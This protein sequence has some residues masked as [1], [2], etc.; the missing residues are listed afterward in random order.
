MDGATPSS[1]AASLSRNVPPSRS[2]CRSCNA[3]ST[4]SME[5]VGRFWTGFRAEEDAG[6]FCT[7]E[8][9]CGSP[10]AARTVS[11]MNHTPP[12]AVPQRSSPGASAPTT[13]DGPASRFSKGSAAA[14]LVCW[15]LVVFD[16]YDLIVY[17]TVQSSLISET[18]WGLNKAKIGRAHV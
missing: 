17:G 4:A 6:L 1:S 3:L 5:Y 13:A 11:G 10:A 16:G 2:N 18:G 15:L 7:S 12:A 8:F 9:Y 14:V